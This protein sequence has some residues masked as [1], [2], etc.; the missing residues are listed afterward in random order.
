MNID[1]KNLSRKENYKLLISSIL[2]RP[3]A[4]ITTEGKDGTINAA[5]FSFF[6]VITAEPPLVGVSVGRKP[7]GSFKDTA[8]NI[9][10]ANNQF[11][12]HIV[13]E[14][15]IE[16]VNQSAANYPAN[17]SEV[18]ETGLTLIK[19]E[20]VTVP[21]IKE[22]KVALEC[23]LHQHMEL[24][25]K[26]DEPRCDF[27]IGEVV[28][29]RVSD[30]LY[31]EGNIQTELLAPVSRLGGVDYGLLGEIISKPRPT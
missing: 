28:S 29:Y 27:I 17:V 2:P 18:E 11:V 20:K 30:S 22:A 1:A 6:N 4:F 15:L 5:P 16:Q 14:T 7:D 26:Q 23:T 31:K 3:I 12:I 8:R 19:S 21:V 25:G 24:G 9:L 13:D 10:E